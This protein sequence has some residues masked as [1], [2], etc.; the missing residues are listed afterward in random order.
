MLGVRL[1]EGLA[2][3]EPAPAAPRLAR[4]GLLDPAALARG[5]ARLTL[6]GRLLADGVARDL[7]RE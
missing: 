4:D 1:A 7:L 6:D 3:R 5:R 2:L